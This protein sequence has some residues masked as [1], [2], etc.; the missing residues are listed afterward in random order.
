M[1]IST[2]LN[3]SGTYQIC[4]NAPL[5]NYTD[6]VKNALTL[7]AALVLYANIKTKARTD[8]SCLFNLRIIL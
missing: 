7:T 4:K 1:T 6:F 3:L 5:S 2:V 8:F